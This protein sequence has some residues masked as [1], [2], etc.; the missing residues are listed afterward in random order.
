MIYLHYNYKN[1]GVGAQYQRIIGILAICNMYN[2]KYVHKKIKVGHNANNV[3]NW[4]DKWDDFFNLKIL[5]SPAPNNYNLYK[6]NIHTLTDVMLERM[7]YNNYINENDDQLIG[8]IRVDKICDLDP[9]TYYG[10][11]IYILRDIYYKKNIDYILDYKNNVTNIAI[12]IR[13]YNEIDI[14]DNNMCDF[15]ENGIRFSG[16]VEYYKNLINKLNK[17]YP[18]SMIH[19]FTQK[20]NNNEKLSK[21]SNNIIMYIDTDTF[22]TMHH[23]IN[24]NVLVMCKSSFSYVAAL[25]NPNDIIY[26]NFWH[27]PLSHWINIDNL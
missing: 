7:I 13:V 23:L 21:L 4:D 19:I 6:E 9:D 18:N 26:V 15:Q 27:A 24:A 14:I 8:L 12:H 20:S 2:F 1:E 17:K 25:Y 11:L 3:K 22:H 5:G 10:S 16:T